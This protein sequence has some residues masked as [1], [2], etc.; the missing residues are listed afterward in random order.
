MFVLDY[1]SAALV[2]ASL[3]LVRKSYKWWLLYFVS[4]ATSVMVMVHSGLYGQVAMITFLGFTGIL[5]FVDGR[6]KFLTHI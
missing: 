5:N 4:C 2:V 1:I 6:R 3:N